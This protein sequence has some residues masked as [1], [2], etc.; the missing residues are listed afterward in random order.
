MGLDMMAYHYN[1]EFG[2]DKYDFFYWRKHPNLHGWMEKLYREKGGTEK[3]FNCV[4]VELTLEDLERLHK[5][6]TEG[7]LPFT[8][9]FFFGESFNDEEEVKKDLRFIS[10]ARAWIESGDKVCYSSWW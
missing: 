4:D 6:V 7:N 2:E 1:P 10:E 9:G 8:S 3:V 5:D